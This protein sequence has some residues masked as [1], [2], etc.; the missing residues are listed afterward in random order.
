MATRENL[1]NTFTVLFAQAER[2]KA[3]ANSMME[4]AKTLEDGGERGAMFLEAYRM[5]GIVH[6]LSEA[7]GAIDLLLSPPPSN[8]NQPKII[9]AH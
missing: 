2:Y 3:E 8:D 5:I 7:L 6:G 4:K 9:L 1:L